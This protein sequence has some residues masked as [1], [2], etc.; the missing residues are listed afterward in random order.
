M[1]R[2]S[3]DQTR[4]LLIETAIDMLHERGA[5]AGVA[6]IKLSEV[7]KR[8]GLTTGAAYRLWD[9]Q[10]AFHQELAA[11]AVRWRDEKTPYVGLMQRLR[12]L[13][14]DNAPLHEILRVGAEVNV[15]SFP[16]DSGFLTTVALRAS[17]VGDATLQA[18]SHRRHREAM[19]AYTDLY[20]A[21]LTHFNRRMRAPFTVEH[22]CRALAA[23]SEGFSLHAISGDSHPTLKMPPT[24]TES[25][26]EW[27][28]L[29]LASRAIVEEFT[30]PTDEV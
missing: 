28:L 4:T 5:A 18:E 21:M 1:A 8:A 13:L 6:H 11:A 19:D 2:R 20:R 14:A 22:L 12:P 15:Y 27:T 24:D 10:A 25:S 17:A 30:E 16:A 9:D 23:L 29:G 26:Q 3:P 7:V